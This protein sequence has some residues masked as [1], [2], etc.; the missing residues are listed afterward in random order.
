MASYSEAGKLIY[1]YAKEKNMSIAQLAKATK[2]SYSHLSN[3]MRGIKNINSKQCNK[4][5]NELRLNG[6]EKSKLR[7]A[8]FISNSSMII[9][10]KNKQL[11]ILKLIYLIVQKS[12]YISQEQAE[13][14]VK[15]ISN[16]KPSKNDRISNVEKAQ[17]EPQNNFNRK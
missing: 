12:P 2:I 4:I 8:V 1:Q 15:I 5:G 13:N 11:F 3:M 7:E 17:N 6:F 14:C 10:T 9:P 16:G